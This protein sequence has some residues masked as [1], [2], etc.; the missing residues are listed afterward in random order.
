ML[1]LKISKVASQAR[2]SSKPPG[3]RP[4]M[5]EVLRFRFAI[6]PGRLHAVRLTGGPTCARTAGR[7]H[8]E[9]AQ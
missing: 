4:A 6:G 9:R 1:R 3:G 2:V 5:G 8:R 7:F